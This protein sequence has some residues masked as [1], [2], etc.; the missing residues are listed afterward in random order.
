MNYLETTE[1]T[2]PCVQLMLRSH[3]RVLHLDVMALTKQYDIL[4]S[5]LKSYILIPV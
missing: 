3:I 1:Q 2:R 5:F 4:A